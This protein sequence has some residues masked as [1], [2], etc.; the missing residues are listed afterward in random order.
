MPRGG[1]LKMNVDGAFRDKV[2]GAGAVLRNAGGR[3]VA[4][5]TTALG[6][7]SGAEEAETRL[8]SWGS[9]CC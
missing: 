3:V 5:T 7:I 6:R 1:G 2:E 4:A 9:A 8:L